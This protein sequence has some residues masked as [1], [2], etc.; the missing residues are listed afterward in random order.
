MARK[1]ATRAFCPNFCTLRAAARRLSPTRCRVAE[2]E[3]LAG[4]DYFYFGTLRAAARRLSLTSC[5]VAECKELAGT[6]YTYF[7]TLRAAALRLCLTSC[8]VAE[9][10]ELAGTDYTFHALCWPPPGDCFQPITGWLS[11]GSSLARTTALLD[12][13]GLFPCLH[14]TGKYC[15]DQGSA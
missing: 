2:C 5:R 11:A 15:H 13:F 12:C 9:R 7:S 6:D 8:R 4:T 3:E 1:L 10:K 14:T